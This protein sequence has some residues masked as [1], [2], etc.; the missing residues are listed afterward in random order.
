MVTSVKEMLSYVYATGHHNYAR[1]GSC[2]LRNIKTLPCQVLEKVMKGE[3]VRRYQE[4]C[5]NGIW[6]DMFIETTF[7]THG[8]GPGG[9]VGVTLQPSIVKK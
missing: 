3:H 2:Y 5:W 8:K 1:Y 7:M 4:G 9:T 6:S